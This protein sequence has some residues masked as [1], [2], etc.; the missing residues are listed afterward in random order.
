MASD[1]MQLYLWSILWSDYDVESFINKVYKR[2]SQMGIIC[3][4]RSCL[5]RQADPVRKTAEGGIVWRM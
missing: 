2:F 1:I 5:C 4:T 3:E